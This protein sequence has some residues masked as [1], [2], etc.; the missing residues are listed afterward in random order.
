MGRDLVRVLFPPK[1]EKVRPLP[2]RAHTDSNAGPGQWLD[3]VFLGSV[4]R[5]FRVRRTGRNW[6]T[7]VKAM[8]HFHVD[9]SKAIDVWNRVTMNYIYRY[10]YCKDILRSPL[11]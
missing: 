6:R 11:A 9:E 8:V 10:I 5:Y 3:P 7:F 4:S 2:W 1:T